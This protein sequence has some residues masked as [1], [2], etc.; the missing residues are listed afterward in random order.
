MSHCCAVKTQSPHTLLKD[1]SSM[2]L[3]AKDHLEDTRWRSSRASAPQRKTSPAAQ[4]TGG[5]RG[6]ATRKATG[7]P[8]T[9]GGAAVP[10]CKRSSVWVRVTTASKKARRTGAVPL[11]LGGG[12]LSKACQPPSPRATG[13]LLGFDTLLL[14]SK[15][16]SRRLA[17]EAMW[18]TSRW[19]T[20][21]RLASAAVAVLII[22]FFPSPVVGCEGNSGT[23]PNFRFTAPRPRNDA[24]FLSG[25]EKCCVAVLS[26][27]FRV[28]RFRFRPARWG[29]SQIPVSHEWPQVGSGVIRTSQ[30]VRGS[31]TDRCT[32]D[33][34]L[35]SQSHRQVRVVLVRVLGSRRPVLFLGPLPFYHCFFPSHPQ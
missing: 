20:S 13:L 11:H 17:F 5:R 6:V 12:L 28:S 33:I 10:R 16:C 18:R 14:V 1:V 2:C 4:R 32:L 19:V 26:A 3:R 27:Y 31:E 21:Q 35:V 8:A 30:A 9:H 34:S 22:H 29:V 24:H 15:T 23:G 7:D 25:A